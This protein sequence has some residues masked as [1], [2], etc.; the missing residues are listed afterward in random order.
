MMFA[1]RIFTWTAITL[2]ALGSIAVFLVFL[3]TTLRQLRG[4][5][6]LDGTPRSR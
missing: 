1:Y 4:G 6:R 3:V 2:L 5:Q